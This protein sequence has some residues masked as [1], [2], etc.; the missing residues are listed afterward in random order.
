MERAG[1][2]Q[3]RSHGA[4]ERR[5]GFI[6]RPDWGRR[7]GWQGCGL[8]GSLCV[9]T[10]CIRGVRAEEPV[11]GPSE[12]PNA[13]RNPAEYALVTESIAIKVGLGCLCRRSSGFR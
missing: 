3:E 12:E 9:Q 11:A 6:T 2:V 5:K 1:D 10:A 4:R 8:D 13:V 7:A